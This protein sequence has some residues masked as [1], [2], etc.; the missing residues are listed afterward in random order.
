VLSGFAPLK[1]G[2]ATWAVIAEIDEAEAFASI[3][4]LKNMMLIIAALGIAA[5]GA[6]G[7]FTASLIANS[8]VG[9]TDAMG[10]L[11]GGDLESNTP[12]QDRSSE[13]GE[14]APAVQ[15]F[16]ENAIRVKQMEEEAKE[17]ERRAA[18]EKTKMMN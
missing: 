3:F 9:M 12:S 6:A 11:A 7:F 4:S 10:V 2:D 5:I 16:K 1:I 18:E 8:V 15:V 14:M 13:I 17:Q